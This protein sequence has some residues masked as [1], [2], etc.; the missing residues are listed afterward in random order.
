MN[1]L[2]IEGLFALKV[3]TETFVVAVVPRVSP[4]EVT[5]KRATFA[6]RGILQLNGPLRGHAVPVGRDDFGVVLNLLG[7][8]EALC[9]VA[10][11]AKDRVAIGNRLTVQ[12]RGKF[13]P[14]GVHVAVTAHIGV[15]KQIPRSPAHGASFNNGNT[16]RWRLHLQV[17][18]R[19]NA[20]KPRTNYKDIDV[21]TGCAHLWDFRDH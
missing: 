16:A 20:R 2:S 14:Q 21:L 8:T 18:G 4:Q 15:A 7:Y 10:D 9:S 1:E 11:I 13:V 12:P 3:G 5:A 17:A 19:A 6:A